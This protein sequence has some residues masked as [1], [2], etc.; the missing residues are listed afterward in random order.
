MT[1]NG[2]GNDEAYRI[3]M[4]MS[5]EVCDRCGDIGGLWVP[6][7]YFDDKPVWTLPNWPD[8]KERTFS[9]KRDKAVYLRSMGFSETGDKVRGANYHSDNRPV[10]DSKYRRECGEAVRDARQ[11]LGYV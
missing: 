1:C 11:K 8:G 9:S 7:V 3:R 10:Y 5:G 6:D 4:F 2:C